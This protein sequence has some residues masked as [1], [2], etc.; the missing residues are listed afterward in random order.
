MGA[1]EALGWWIVGV[2]LLGWM[3]WLTKRGNWKNLMASP[4]R[5]VLTAAVG[6][7][8]ILALVY[9]IKAF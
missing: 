4:W 3:V 7:A 5:H 2:L 9:T 1:L 6:G 8:L